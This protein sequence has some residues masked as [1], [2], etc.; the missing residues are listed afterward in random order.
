MFF[1]QACLCEHVIPYFTLTW[2]QTEL[3]GRL[4]VLTPS[5]NVDTQSPHQCSCYYLRDLFFGYMYQPPSLQELWNLHELQFFSL[6]I[7]SLSLSLFRLVTGGIRLGHYTYIFVDEA[8][9]AT[10]TECII[11]IAG[12][13]AR[14]RIIT[15]FYTAF[16]IQYNVFP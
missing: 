10:E 2:L 5:S 13:N 11:P 4:T 6:N 16:D 1:E 12:E 3:S 7:C 8:G 14:C 9:Q 15:V